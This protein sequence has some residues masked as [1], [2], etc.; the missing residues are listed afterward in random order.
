MEVIIGHLGPNELK[1]LLT[2]PLHT[3]KQIKDAIPKKREEEGNRTLNNF[4]NAVN[5]ASKTVTEMELCKRDDRWSKILEEL[6]GIDRRASE[7][8]G[9]DS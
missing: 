7:F 1:N 9:G 8:L 4:Q 2:M 3:Q 5:N 6:D